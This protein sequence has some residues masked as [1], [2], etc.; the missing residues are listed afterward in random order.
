MHKK[1]LSSLKKFNTLK[2]NTN[3]V[4]TKI[5]ADMRVYLPTYYQDG[6]HPNNR[7]YFPFYLSYANRKVSTASPSFLSAPR[8]VSDTVVFKSFVKY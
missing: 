7:R 2:K 4:S 3:R 5:F 8:S 1:C 6:K